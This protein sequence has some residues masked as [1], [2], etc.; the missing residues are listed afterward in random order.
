MGIEPV[1]L[2]CRS[3][4]AAFQLPLEII[5]G[6]TPTFP[7]HAQSESLL[8]SPGTCVL[9]DFG[10]AETLPEQHFLPAALVLCRVISRTSPQSVTLD[11]GHKS[12]AAEN[13]LDKRVRFLN[14]SNYRFVSQSEEHLVIEGEGVR[15]LQLGDPL[16][17]I[18]YHICPTTAL[19]DSAVTV[20]SGEITGTWEIPARKRICTY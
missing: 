1:L 19:Y 5:A 10:Y 20:I 18:P 12:I 7:V 6:G 2:L 3:L 16:Y 4:T 8:C 14:L 17:G 9:W 11:L 15:H 13:I